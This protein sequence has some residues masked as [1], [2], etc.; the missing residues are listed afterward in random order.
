MPA[1]AAT[2]TDTT[3]NTSSSEPP[4][5]KAVVFKSTVPF[6]H[7]RKKLP[8][9]CLDPAELNDMTEQVLNTD[10]GNLFQFQRGGNTAGSS[11]NEQTDAWATADGTVQMVEY[12]MRG[13]A[14]RV[15]GTLWD[16]WTPTGASTGT[17]TDPMESLTMM[18]QLLARMWDEG[19]VYMK[20]RKEHWSQMAFEEDLR[21]G[22]AGG[23]SGDWTSFA[24][25]GTEA[26]TTANSSQT[27]EEYANSSS[28]GEDGGADDTTE[29]FAMPGPSVHMYDMYLDAIASAAATI[30]AADATSLLTASNAFNTFETVMYRHELDGGD[31]GN[32]NRHTMP[33]QISYNAVLRTAANLPFDNNGS[34]VQ[35]DWALMAAFSTH[36]ALTHSA[37]ERNSSTY[38]YLLQVVAKYM[39]PSTSRGNIARGLWKLAKTNGVY[40]DQVKEAFLMA[41]ATSNSEDHDVWLDE[42]IRGKDWRTDA[43]Q[44]WRRRV[45]KYRMVPKQ[46][47]Y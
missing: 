7:S 28:N 33:T 8:P 17:S 19:H 10:H 38:A 20:V 23:S 32:N 2:T 15:P 5:A 26:S 42:N 13:H 9:A 11:G 3:T 47:T 41:N 14:A 43:P 21:A 40:N 31:E 45:Q 35:R 1:A 27:D 30:P 4:T 12:L 22:S 46:T 6:L 16:G 39:P 18:D 29:D 37:L 24:R 36:D 44:R 34:E 25:E